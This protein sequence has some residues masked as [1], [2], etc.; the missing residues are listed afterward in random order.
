MQSRFRALAARGLTRFTGRDTEKAH[1][2]RFL[3]RVQQGNGHV[4]AVIGEPGIGKSRLLHEFFRVKRHPQL[5]ALET[6]SVSYRKTT[7]YAPIIDLL[8]TYFK[9]GD[10]DATATIRDKV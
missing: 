10:R 5:L 1:I 2:E 6:A 9:I 3:G 4:V 7:S 8:K